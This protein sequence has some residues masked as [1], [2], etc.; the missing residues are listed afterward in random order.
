MENIFNHFWIHLIFYAPHPCSLGNFAGIATGGE[1]LMANTACSCLVRSF[2]FNEHGVVNN[3]TLLLSKVTKKKLFCASFSVLKRLSLWDLSTP[4]ASPPL[5]R[6]VE[7]K[8]SDAQRESWSMICK[9]PGGSSIRVCRKM[10][11]CCRRQG[12]GKSLGQG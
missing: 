6:R 9:R 5:R 2:S 3:L 1:L 8:K 4:K 11:S 7:A 10:N 12:K